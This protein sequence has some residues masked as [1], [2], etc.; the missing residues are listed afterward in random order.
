MNTLCKPLVFIFVLLSFSPVAA[1]AEE[2]NTTYWIYTYSSELQ[3][4][5][6]NGVENDELVINNGNWD[7]KIPLGELEFIALP[8]KPG[9]LGQLIGGGLGGYCG[10]V[11]GLVLGFIT[12]GVT[13]AHENG[14][15]IV[16]GG[17]LGGAIAGVY[18]GSRFG[19]NL[20]KG[21]PETLV[22]MAMW[23]LDEKKEWIQNSLISS[24]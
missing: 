16:V 13:G 20:L 12:W 14:G 5:Q 7:V 24:Y 4:Y 22:D 17:A 3:D 23:S 2:G 15:F 11:V 21:P 6:I 10:G 19:G 1:Q 8:P 9:T 18:Y